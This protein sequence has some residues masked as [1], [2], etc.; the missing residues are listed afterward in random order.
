MS[1]ALEPYVDR[2]YI[3]M[4]AAAAECCVRFG[5]VRPRFAHASAR[6]LPLLLAEIVSVIT[7][8]GRNIVVSE[9]PQAREE[10]ESELHHQSL[11]V[12]N[13]SSLLLFF[14]PQGFL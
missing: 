7:C 2:Q 9:C 12:Q 3:V 13:S 6:S 1:V 4:L 10:A 8:D 11:R 14:C 5:C